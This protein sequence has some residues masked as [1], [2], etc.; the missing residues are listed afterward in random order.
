MQKRITQCGDFE[1]QYLLIILVQ[2]WLSWA[3]K[4]TAE[5]YLEAAFPTVSLD[6]R[7]RLLETGDFDYVRNVFCL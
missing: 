6:F 4:Q 2:Q 1:C 5:N 3:G 7:M